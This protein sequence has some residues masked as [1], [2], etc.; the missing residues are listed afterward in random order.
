MHQEVSGLEDLRCLIRDEFVSLRSGVL[1]PER[2]SRLLER[3]RDS[4]CQLCV[5]ECLV[6]HAN[7][8]HIQNDVAGRGAYLK[9]IDEHLTPELDE[10]MSPLMR[11]ALTFPRFFAALNV[12]DYESALIHAAEAERLASEADFPDAV[13]ATLNLRGRLAY[14]V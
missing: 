1:H 12:G 13:G 6:T 9:E 2:T 11:W 14:R 4:D 8:C 10:E 5:L 7:Q 3:A